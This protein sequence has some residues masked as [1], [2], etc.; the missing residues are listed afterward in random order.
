MTWQGYGYGMIF[1]RY[2]LIELHRMKSC[3]TI[4][5][6]ASTSLLVGWIV[7]VVTQPH[8]LLRTFFSFSR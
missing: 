8:R 6:Y 4:L 5:G 7:V 1:G 3:S 2:A